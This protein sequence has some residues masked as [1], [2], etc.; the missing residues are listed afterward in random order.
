MSIKNFIVVEYLSRAITLN[1]SFG[2]TNSIA[3]KGFNLRPLIF[4]YFDMVEWLFRILKYN[5]HICKQDLEC[6]RTNLRFE[7]IRSQIYLMHFLV[8]ML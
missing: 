8:E 7:K 2:F 3:Q 6:Q 5:K 4:I 1:C